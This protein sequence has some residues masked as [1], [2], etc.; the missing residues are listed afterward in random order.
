MIPEVF[1]TPQVLAAGQFSF[2]VPLGK[3]HIPPM[4]NEAF[5]IKSNLDSRA[6]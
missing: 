2:G 1:I 3:K 4:N 5:S 6:C